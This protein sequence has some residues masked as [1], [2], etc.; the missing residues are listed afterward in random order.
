MLEVSWEHLSRKGIMTRSSATFIQPASTTMNQYDFLCDFLP[1]NSRKIGQNPPPQRLVHLFVGQDISRLII[2][3]VTKFAE[4][5][6]KVR[7]DYTTKVWIK[8]LRVVNHPGLVFCCHFV[9]PK[10]IWS[11]T[12]LNTKIW[13][14]S[15]RVFVSCYQYYLVFSPAVAVVVVVVVVVVVAAAAAVVVVTAV[16]YT[17]LHIA[18]YSPFR[19]LIFV[20]ILKWTFVM[21]QDFAARHMACQYASEVVERLNQKRIF[22]DLPPKAMMVMAAGRSNSRLTPEMGEVRGW[23]AKCWGCCSLKRPI[24][25]KVVPNQDGWGP[26]RWFKSWSSHNLTP[27]WLH[28]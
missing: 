14:S 1:G 27:P 7:E 24:F 19:Y 15:G 3:E 10:R 22:S 17:L 8:T 26:G 28:V 11:T 12:N 2:I 5:I 21:T 4:C 13:V 20:Y 9:S 16:P 6:A 25:T 18:I 23:L